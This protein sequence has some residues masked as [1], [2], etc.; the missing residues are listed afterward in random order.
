MA[1]NEFT[2]TT[3]R[4]RRIRRDLL[5]DIDDGAVL[6]VIARIGGSKTQIRKAWS[7]ALKKTASKLRM[8]AMK[9][10]RTFI[11]PRSPRVFKRRVLVPPLIRGGG[12]EFDAAKIWFGLNAIK[13]RDLRGRI[14]GRR[15]EERHTLRDAR[16]RFAP[17]TRRRRDVRFTPAGAMPAQTF[18]N[19]YVSGFESENSRGRISRR[20]TIMVRQS[21]GRRRV[22][23][24]EVD[25]YDVMANRIE[26]FVFPQAEALI[27]K[28]FEHEL[29]FR[30]LKGMQC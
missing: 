24:A 16:G 12:D 14:S 23:E 8:D 10:V 26:D 5:V 18:E 4:D 1:I 15:S 17:A 11:A 6:D 21:G 9:E 28:N 7:V 30:V 25:I 27:M 19:A 20:A 2:R 13:V 22:R 29:R 3:A